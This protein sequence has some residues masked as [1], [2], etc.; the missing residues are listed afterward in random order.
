MLMLAAAAG[1]EGVV[2]QLLEAGAPW[3]AVDRKGDCAGDYAREQGH[4]EVY[5]TI[6][7][8]GSF[9][10]PCELRTQSPSSFALFRK[11]DGINIVDMNCKQSAAQGAGLR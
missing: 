7:D 11:L 10:F 1:H 4:E 5:E 9:S 2:T 6:V 8:A 3:N